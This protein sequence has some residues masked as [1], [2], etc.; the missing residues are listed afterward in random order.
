MNFQSTRCNSSLPSNSSASRLHF[1]FE[2]WLLFRRKCLE[3]LGAPRDPIPT[4]SAHP[5]HVHSAQATTRQFNFILWTKAHNR[6]RCAHN[7]KAPR[8]QQLF[9]VWFEIKRKDCFN[10]FF[11]NLKINV[12]GDAA[13]ILP[14]IGFARTD[15]SSR[16]SLLIATKLNSSEILISKT[17]LNES[18]S[19][20]QFKKLN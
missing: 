1:I 7:S 12:R 8:V 16:H 6:G 19:K 13:T 18:K 3:P 17:I 9:W 20:I 10:Y 5:A 4:P 15:K 11:P 14:L 2:F